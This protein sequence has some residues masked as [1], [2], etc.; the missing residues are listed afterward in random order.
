MHDPCD[1]HKGDS[2]HKLSQ[3]RVKYEMLGGTEVVVGRSIASYDL[4][5]HHGAVVIRHRAPAPPPN[6]LTTL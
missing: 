3:E 2:E 5:Q 1:L 6:H 4:M